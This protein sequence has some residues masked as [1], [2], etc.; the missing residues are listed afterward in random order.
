M[1]IEFRMDPAEED[2]SLEDRSLERRFLEGS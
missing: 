2:F 1:I